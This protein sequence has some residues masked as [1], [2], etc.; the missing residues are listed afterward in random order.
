MLDRC[1]NEYVCLM[2]IWGESLPTVRSR[3]GCL[4]SSLGVIVLGIQRVDVQL[5]ESFNVLE[6]LSTKL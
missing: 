2:F 3:F 4:K 1:Q 6:Y 5:F